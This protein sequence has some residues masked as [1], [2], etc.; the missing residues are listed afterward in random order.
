MLFVVAVSA[1]GRN[2]NGT[3][4]VDTAKSGP[5]PSM[6][7]PATPRPAS[8]FTIK[9]DAK[10]FV[11]TTT[12][13]GADSV[14]MYNLDGS[15]SKNTPP[16]RAAVQRVYHFAWDGDKAVITTKGDT[17]EEKTEYW[18]EGDSLVRQTERPGSGGAAPAKIKTYFKRAK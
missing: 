13:N 7:N 16:G 4:T 14:M 10:T 12:R 15:D 9:V 18:L 2:F 17:G 8:D 1:Q 3:W 6:T 11:V 5:A